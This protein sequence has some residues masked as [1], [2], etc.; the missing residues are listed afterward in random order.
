MKELNIENLTVSLTT[1]GSN[2]QVKSDYRNI[3]L[4]NQNIDDI[5]EVIRGSF[6]IVKNHYENL[7]FKREKLFNIT[8]I[9]HLSLSIVLHYLY[10]YNS[11]KIMY[12]KQENRNLNFDEK[13]FNN[14]STYDIIFSYLKSKYP[15]SWE[16]QSAVLLDI[17]LDE[18]K[19]YYK[20]RE[21]FYNK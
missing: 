21:E 4:V 17:K 6:N 13:D 14:P 8:D 5:T 16:L 3:L 18:L 19:I 7:A 20:T 1:E 2:I 12:K 10:L 11:W 15:E 9:Y